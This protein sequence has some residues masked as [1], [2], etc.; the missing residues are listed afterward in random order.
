MRERVEVRDE[1]P[2]ADS[3]R[4]RRPVV[5]VLAPYYLPGYRGGGPV[6]SIS[7]LVDALKDSYRFLIVARDHDL[8]DDRRY[9]K[10]NGGGWVSVRQGRVFYL[11]GGW[12]GVFRL[13][14]LLRRARY[15]V[16]YLNTFFSPLFSILPMA[17]RRAHLVAA[18]PVVVAPR[19]ELSP[20]ALGLKRGKKRLFL[21]CAKA[22]G[23]YTGRR[24]VW[25]ASTDLEAA[26]IRSVYPRAA[27]GVAPPFPG[28]GAATSRLAGIA[29]RALTGRATGAGA[30]RS[31]PRRDGCLRV[32]FVSRISPKKNLLG[33]IRT[34]QRSASPVQFTIAGPIE[35]ASYWRQCQDELASLPSG[36]AAEYVGAMPHDVVS[37]LFAAHDVFL[38][39]TLAENYGHVISEALL[40]GCPVI[41][42][43]ETPW[44]DLEEH[45]AGFCLPLDRAEDW[46]A[47]LATYAQASDADYERIRAA[48]RAYGSNRA[49][50][51]AIIRQ[52]LALFDQAV[53]TAKSGRASTPRGPSPR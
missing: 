10:A 36:S 24:L 53:A 37:R 43:D 35:D 34:V 33:A 15:D 29:A 45:G 11:T 28:K 9:E 13:W 20:G 44:R 3:A 38:F 27:V 23:L 12:R 1:R 41:T 8:G 30:A 18:R 47:A 6:R 52:N 42:S 16:L 5:L 2:R 7:N 40:A 39:P 50:E 26:D 32:V 17:L 48:A 25:Q 19:G 31:A 51:P 22:V 21:A 14:S 46:D 49:S 4:A